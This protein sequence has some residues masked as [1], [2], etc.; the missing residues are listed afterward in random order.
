MIDILILY[1]LNKSPLTMY[2]ISKQISTQFSVFIKPSMGTI[3]PALK[4]LEKNGAVSCQKYMSK[5]GR[6]SICYAI[7]GKGKEELV[8]KM[9]SPLADN[10]IQFAVNARIRL[11]C[12]DILDTE[13]YKTMLRI[14]KRKAELLMTET[15]KMSESNKIPQQSEIIFDNLACEYRN[16]FSLLEG[17]EHACNG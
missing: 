15:K 9:T 8:K 11:C 5:G 2:G 6:P 16:L 7:T 1:E 12:A 13:D 17:L 10:P 3:Q 14:L 4:N